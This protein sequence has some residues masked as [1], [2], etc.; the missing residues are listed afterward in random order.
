MKILGFEVPKVI[1]GLCKP[2]QFY[3]FLSFFSV[4]VYLVSMLRMNDAVVEAEPEGGHVHHYTFGGLL[5]KIVFTVLWVYILN[6][7]CQFKYGKKI[8]WFIVLLPFFFM[9]LALVGLFTAVSFIAL[10]NEKQKHLQT[11]LNNQ[12]NMFMKREDELKK[13]LQPTQQPQ[14]APEN[15]P[16]QQVI[17]GYQK[18]Y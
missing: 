15:N 18:G 12:K 14:Q 7:I 9:A 11:E 2:A 8:S 3:L 5:V 1:Q 13:N 16:S 4:I 6:Y 10:Q 17:E